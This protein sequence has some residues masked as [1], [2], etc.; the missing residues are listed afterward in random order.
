MVDFAIQTEGLV[1]RFGDFT[2]VDG[3]DLEVLPGTFYGFLGPNGAGKSTTIKMLTGLLGMTSGIARVLGTNIEHDP[4][5]VKRS[6]GVV[7]EELALF[8]R[9]TGPEYLLFVGRMHGL[10]RS[11]I[12]QRTDELL[13]LMELQDDRKKLI[14]DYSHGMKKKISF[15]AS[16]IHNPK[17]LFLDEP[18]EGIDAISSQQIKRIL[19]QLVLSGVTVFLTSHILE[20]VERLCTHI[21]IINHG[22]LVVHGSLAELR[23]LVETETGEARLEALFLKLVGGDRT[24]KRG[25]SWLA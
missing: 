23:N 17:L 24:T 21:A 14:V 18:F 10:E 13:E 16:L 8:D 4:V 1:R 2:A 7:P 11:I 25:L 5:L 22:K 9:L 6:I 19:S 3:L 20:I 12:T 15:V